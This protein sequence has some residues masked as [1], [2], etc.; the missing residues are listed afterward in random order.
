MP[1]DRRGASTENNVTGLQYNCDA[2]PSRRWI[3][4]L[5]LQRLGE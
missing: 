4:R 1:D 3:L 2:D 5:K